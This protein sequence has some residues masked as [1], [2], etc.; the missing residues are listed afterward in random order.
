M[1]ATLSN[2]TVRP[3]GA[4]RAI[5][6]K[7]AKGEPR[8]PPWPWERLPPFEQRIRVLCEAAGL[9]P[10]RLGVSAGLSR[11][12]I[13][14]WIKAAREGVALPGTPE[15]LRRLAERRSVS[16]EWLTSPAPLPAGS[17]APTAEE[18]PALPRASA[19]QDRLAMLDEAV[20]LLV[21]RDGL[22]REQ[23]WDLMIDVR[24]RQPSGIAFYEGG[25]RKLLERKARR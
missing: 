12:T 23:A 1:H 15:S 7:V 11:E 9:G 17:V 8:N 3:N 5:V 2:E 19:A 25:W 20:A 14:K 10:A 13:P 18:Q 21:V 6:P 16:F 4:P 22:T 24:P